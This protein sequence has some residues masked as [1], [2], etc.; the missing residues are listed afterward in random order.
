MN[1]AERR[2]YLIKALLSEDGKYEGMEIP[3][4]KK[5]QQDLL[6]ALM[7]VR[8]PAPLDRETLKIQDEYL[9]KRNEER[10][11][12]AVDKLE[13]AAEQTGEDDPFLQKAVIWQGDITR[14]QAGAIVNAA[15]S[16]MLG[17]FRPLHNCID[18]CIQTY[19]GMQLRYACY[20]YMET[21]KKK[22]GEGYQEPT[23]RAVLTDGY[24][25]PADHVIHTV[26]P[27]VEY[28]LTDD[29]RDDLVSCYGSI[30]DCAKE[31]GIRSVAFC[32]ISTG[33]F[34][35][36]ADEA[37][38]IAV[39]TVRN[40]DWENEG[41]LDRIVFNVFKDS[42]REYYEGLLSSGRMC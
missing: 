34:R 9:K 37:A 15:N 4:G 1:Q 3:K 42:D 36:P 16:G 22:Y 17:C 29:L 7:N 6:R 27:I 11:I 35:F 40:W 14:L 32:C 21:M 39:D 10:G 41:S 5:E 19:A 25:L 28:E 31:N 24:N 26:G 8:M 20:R 23:G 18:N 12:A 38:R 2:M 13:T 30:L 33:V